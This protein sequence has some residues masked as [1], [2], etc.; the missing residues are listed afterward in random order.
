M[1][2]KTRFLILNSGDVCNHPSFHITILH[3]DTTTA[4]EI[5]DDV[6]L[7]VCDDKDDTK[8]GSEFT[9]YCK[10]ETFDHKELIC[11]FMSDVSNCET[12]LKVHHSPEIQNI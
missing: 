10:F 11:I 5:E 6:W 12:Y 4:D 8:V 3:A 7:E 1:H 9:L 2:E